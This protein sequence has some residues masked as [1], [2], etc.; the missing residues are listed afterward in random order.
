MSSTIYTPGWFM[1][2]A[3]TLL[4]LSLFLEM[5][6][7]YF[8]HRVNRLIRKHQKSR[9]L[10]F[11]VIIS[12]NPVCGYEAAAPGFMDHRTCAASKQLALSKLKDEIESEILLSD[13]NGKSFP[14]ESLIEVRFES[15]RSD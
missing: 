6:W 3:F 4:I 1:V 14:E 7:F 2:F 15:Q 12:P 9:L 8:L 11:R 5:Y 10:Q 13:Y